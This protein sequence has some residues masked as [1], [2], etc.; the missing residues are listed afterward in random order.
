VYGVSLRILGD[1]FSANEIGVEVMYDFLAKYVHQLTCAEATCTYLQ[2]M[3]ARRATRERGRRKHS[4]LSDI[5][6]VTAATDDNT[7]ERALYRM[8][9]PRLETCLGKLTPKAQRVVKLRF[10]AEMTNEE[11]GGVV[12]SSKQYIGRLLA[13][14]MVSLRRCL[15][16]V[17]AAQPGGEA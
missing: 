16:R 17:G 5:G 6:D 4:S 10:F 12:G 3:T 8:L 9:G 13:K 1:S 11:I 7:E 2:L 15:L 14:V